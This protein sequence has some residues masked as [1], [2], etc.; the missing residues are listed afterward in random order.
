MEEFLR[1][2]A[3]G[4]LQLQP[5]ITHQFALEEAAQAYQT[6][7]NPASNSLA[8]LLQYPS[9][10]SANVTAFEPQRRIQVPARTEP[11]AD[12]RVAL[13]GAGNLARW[14]HLPN[15]KKMPRVALHAV[16]SASGA[17]GKSYAERFGAAYSC[18]D[19]EEILRDPKIDVV[20]IVSRHQH[21]FSQA[22][23]ALQAGKHV[24]LEK[25]MALTEE[26]CRQ[27]YR[28]VEETGKQLTVGFNRRFAPFY[29]EQKKSLS[30]RTS[31]AIVN[32]RMNSP[33]LSGSFWA[34]DPAY[35]GA[36]VG[37]GCHFVDLMY[38]LLE[39]EPVSVS[40]YCLPIGKQDPIGEN[41]MV[42]SFRY[43][44]GSIGNLTY[45]TVGSKTSGGE[46]VEVFAQGVG[47]V[48]EDFKSLTV[49]T[50]TKRERSRWW[51]EKGHGAQL[52]A[53]LKG[54]LS[55]QQPDVTVR[56][57]ARATIGCLR[58]LESAK[59]SN[60]CVIDLEAVLH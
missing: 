7:M 22:L 47:V 49:K 19:Y 30:R 34:A 17:R 45:C 38:W 1:Q 54:I 50:E 11:P 23:A 28:A 39:S 43:A 59:T 31:P 46:H 20:L 2:I 40:A 15:L 27:L 24:F 10:T 58:M 41:N 14:V 55:G 25:P 26:E 16:H 56:D 13:V 51:P 53:F 42:A 18:S 32:C 4:R 36:I 44:D 33:G 3:L 52:E 5:L 29:V 8:V 35:G 9:L 48:T 21:H 12:L 60:P 57:G 37:E 6:I